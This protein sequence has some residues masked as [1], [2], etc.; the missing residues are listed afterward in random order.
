MMTMHSRTRELLEHLQQSRAALRAAVDAVPAALREKEPAPDRWSIAQ[1]LEHL[2][3]VE[4]GITVMLNR[5][6]RQLQKEGLKPAS[7]DSPVLPTIDRDRLLDREKKLTAPESA[8]PK[9]Q[10]TCDQALQALADSRGGLE[11]A[12]RAGDGCDVDGVHWA[13]PFLGDLRFHQWVAF[14]GFHE[15]RHADQVAATGKQLQG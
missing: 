7:D 10:L 14:V 9:K 8:Q 1:V 4:S 12:L 2:L 5:G 6:L 3:Q 13:H 11:E 15:Q